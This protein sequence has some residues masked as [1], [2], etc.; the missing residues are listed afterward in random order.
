MRYM[1]DS[2]FAG[3]ERCCP[4]SPAL[5]ARDSRVANMSMEHNGSKHA[6]P[7]KRAGFIR[8]HSAR[9]QQMLLMHIGYGELAMG[10]A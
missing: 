1:P 8:E 7:V 9:H 3:L 4:P 10:R 5:I 2:L 6:P